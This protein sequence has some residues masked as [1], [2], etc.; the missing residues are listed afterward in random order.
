MLN[1]YTN[2]GRQDSRYIADLPGFFTVWYNPSSMIN[3]LAWSD[4]RR[5]YRIT[6]DT[7][8]GRYI[9]VHL[10]PDRRTIFEEVGSG[11]YL[12]RNKAQVQYAKKV[13]RHSYLI[14]TEARLSDFKNNE[15]QRAKETRDLH[16][17]L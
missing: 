15:I 5:R 11:L 3:I 1:D 6:A 4:V 17:A 10:S 2:K 16:R 8:I 7:S 14:L 12:F 9:P 13:S